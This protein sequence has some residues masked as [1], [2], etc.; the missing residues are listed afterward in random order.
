MLKRLINLPGVAGLVDRLP[1]L[2]PDVR[3]EFD[4]WWERPSYGYGMHFAARLAYSLDIPR[5]T[6]MEWGVVQGD[7]LMWMERIARTIFE[8]VGVGIDVVAFDTGRGLPEPVDYRDCP[9]IW[10]EGFYTTDERRVRSLISDAELILGPMG[11]SIADYLAREDA[12]PVGF[13]ACN[14]DY[15]SLA[16]QALNSVAASRTGVRL[17]RVMTLF[18]DLL[19]PERACHNAWTGE[20]LAIR[21]FNETHDLMKIDKMHHLRW[22]RRAPAFWHEMVYVLHDFDHPLYTRLI[23]PEGY[24]HRQL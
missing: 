7:G 11:P 15:Y 5:I 8:H 3:A 12:A 17:P 20:R 14:L 4:L 19:F 1:G 13:I 2:S 9:H 22:M 21:E 16:I 18:D 24:E 6:V 10:D 23:T